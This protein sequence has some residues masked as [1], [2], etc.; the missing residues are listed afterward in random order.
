MHLISIDWDFFTLN[1]ELESDVW[2][3]DNRRSMPGAL[4]YDWQM[5]ENRAPEFESAL[6]EIRAA[7]LIR[8]GCEPKHATRPMVDVETFI[9]EISTRFFPGVAWS[10]DSHSWAGPIARQL[11]EMGG[12]GLTVWN[13]DAHHDLG[14]GDNPVADPERI[15]CDDWALLGLQQGW[16]KNYNL[17]YP[18]FRGRSEWEGVKRPHLTGFR[19]ARRIKVMTWTEFLDKVDYGEIYADVFMCRSS[20]W[21]PPWWDGEFQKLRE[22]YEPRCIECDNPDYKRH[23]SCTPREWDWQPVEEHVRRIEDA[24]KLHREFMQLQKAG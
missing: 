14:Y 5:S 24:E 23:D 7:N 1:R 13:F 11:A 21:T 22:E 10:A 19:K 9:T 3:D 16:I 20:S 6:W 15:M 2:D 12:G 4:L 17:V 8:F 18:D